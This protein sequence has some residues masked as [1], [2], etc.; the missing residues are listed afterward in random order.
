[1]ANLHVFPVNNFPVDIC[2]TI[3]FGKYQ[4]AITKAQLLLETK[5][6]CICNEYSIPIWKLKF[7]P[8][9]ES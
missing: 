9:A 6:S 5:M 8:S 4:H 7:Q 1:M 3:Y 2:K